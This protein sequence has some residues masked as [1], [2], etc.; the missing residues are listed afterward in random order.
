MPGKKYTPKA[1]TGPRWLA[2]V[3]VTLDVDEEAIPDF[4]K[5][6]EYID[7]MMYEDAAAQGTEYVVLEQIE[8]YQG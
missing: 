3:I 7:D 2:R 5:L 1:R 4:N 8:E 6:C